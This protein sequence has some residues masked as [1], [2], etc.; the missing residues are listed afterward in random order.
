MLA[1]DANASRRLVR[2][3]LTPAWGV[4]LGGL[5]AMAVHGATGPEAP[6]TTLLSR[7]PAYQPVEGHQVRL[8]A[9][10]LEIVVADNAAW[11]PHHRAGYNGL[12]SLTHTAE[13]RNLFVP[14]YAGLNLE[15]ILGGAETRDGPDPL[16]E[17]RQCP[18][19]LR[20][21]GDLRVEMH[22]PPTSHKG[23]E[24]AMRFT[25]VPPHY[26]D[27]VYECIPRRATFERGYAIVFWASYIHAP[28]DKAI[29]FLGR[30][31]GEAAGERWITAV[32]PAHGQLSTHR[33][34]SDPDS[35]PP[36]P[37]H[38][39]T[40]VFHFSKYRYTR[41]FYYGRFHDMVY[42]IQFDDPA[43]VR[44]S[45]SPTGGGETN[46]AWDW[47]FLIRDCRVGHLYRLRARVVYKKFV[48]EADCLAEDEAWR[49]ALALP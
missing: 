15:H 42:Q 34:V 25:L 37:N 1:R 8:A 44:L 31:E 35:P 11:P 48:S 39:L 4:T 7:P 36:V 33:W 17:P 30:E 16:F 45:Q 10:D 22:Q 28:P 19:E 49:K 41:P 40:L 9:G 32:S 24:S 26:V 3:F 27:V 2:R 38:P 6:L 29:H 21:V 46:P 47:Q 43:R 14:A 23:L 12:A 13:P 18:I 20:R 5:L